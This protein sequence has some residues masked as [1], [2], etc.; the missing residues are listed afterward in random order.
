[1]AESDGSD[2]SDVASAFDTASGGRGSS[3]DDRD[4]DVLTPTAVTTTDASLR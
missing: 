4:L 3:H 1:V 2:G